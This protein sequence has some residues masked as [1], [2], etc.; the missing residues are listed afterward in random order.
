MKKREQPPDPEA[1]SALRR[2]EAQLDLTV[3]ELRGLLGGLDPLDRFAAAIATMDLLARLR[4]WQRETGPPLVIPTVLGVEATQ[5]IQFFRPA[6]NIVASGGRTGQ[7]PE[8]DLP[9]VARKATVLRVYIE[10]VADVSGTLEWRAVGSAAWSGPLPALNAPLNP[11]VDPIATRGSSSASLNF[12]LPATACVG[13]LEVRLSFNGTARPQQSRVLWDLFGHSHVQSGSP[14][15]GPRAL[16]LP[17]IS[18][19]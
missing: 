7:Q 8:N 5:S 18:K 19:R 17:S 1:Q 12:R 10:N 13:D 6:V 2:L 14:N 15:S 11:P 4:E 3:Q 9:L 16:C